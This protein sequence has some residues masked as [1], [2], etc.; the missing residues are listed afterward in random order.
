MMKNIRYYIGVFLLFIGTA[1]S[2][3][4]LSPEDY[5][6]SNNFWKTEAQA[7]GFMIGLHSNFRG[8]A[9]TYFMLGEL[10]GG[11]LKSGTSSLGT[12]LNYENTIL[13]NFTKDNFD[14][15]FHNWAGFYGRILNINLAIDQLNQA[16]YLSENQKNF[17]L[18]QA[19]GL[20]AWYYF[21]L[22]RTYGGVPIKTK[23]EVAKGSVTAEQLYTAR[24]TAKETLDF[25]K[26]DIKKSEDYF[27][28]STVDTKSQWTRYAT[29]MLKA[30]IYLWSAKVTT[31]NQTP[32]DVSGDL[33][34]AEEALNTVK[35][36]GK[37][38]LLPDFNNVFRYGNKEN[39]EIIFTIPFLETEATNSSSL[40]LYST[41]GLFNGKYKADGTQ[42][43]NDPLKIVS[44]GGVLRIE[45]KYAFFEKFDMEDTRRNVTFF[46][47]Y[48][49]SS[50]GNPA[51]VMPKFIGM[52]NSSNVRRYADDI[53]IY[54][55][56]DVL[57]M[58][59]EIKNKKNQDPSEEINEI[60]KRAYG[61]NYVA[62]THGYTNGSFAENELAIL[63]ERDKEFVCENKRW[64]DVRRMQDAS[65]EPLVFSQNINYGSTTPILNQSE[66][67]R[68]LM[69][70][71][72]AT[73]NGDPKLEQT[74]G[75][76]KK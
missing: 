65:G 19:Y 74:E 14:G 72:S 63:L 58:L 73:L 54:R 18:G 1:C 24:A 23:P 17:Y 68:L 44:A 75:Y 41:D 49:D 36:S 50:K 5:Y 70:I 46:D 8:N 43:E 2:D 51:V 25:I 64:F 22:Y 31:G 4:D 52:I 40:F 76:P 69:P 60:R 3:L 66:K 53:P 67:Y 34:K 10:R 16:N 45:Y 56:A 38:S 30:E 13:Q 37:Y 27:G 6:G 29:L 21:W 42:Y 55:Y 26:E 7:K 15:A 59:A 39:A 71:N 12:S 35:S 48:S 33:E 57:L 9:F 20:R 28:N 47:F 32:T 62:S 11:L 61:S